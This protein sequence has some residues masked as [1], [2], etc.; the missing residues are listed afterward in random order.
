MQMY[1]E[2]SGRRQGG[3]AC[4]VHTYILMAGSGLAAESRTDR[5]VGRVV[6]GMAQ[7][8]PTFG[9]SQPQCT[10]GHPNFWRKEALNGPPQL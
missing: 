6:V 7:A 8:T 5:P 2:G 4:I 1:V 3:L 9:R 10:V